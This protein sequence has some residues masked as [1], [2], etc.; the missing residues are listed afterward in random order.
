[1]RIRIILLSPLV[2]PA[3]LVLLLGCEVVLDVERLADLLRR[4]ALD[5]VGN[6][7]T[8]DV[9]ECLDV[10]VVGRLRDCHQHMRP[11]NFNQS[12]NLSPG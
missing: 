1:M 2:L 4:L 12:L 6:G 7:F 3:D 10:K 9:Q 5:H 8:T 11:A